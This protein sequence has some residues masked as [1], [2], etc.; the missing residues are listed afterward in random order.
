MT[1]SA[2]I[3]AA[4]QPIT[5]ATA[6]IARRKKTTAQGGKPIASAAFHT[7]QKA[8]AVCA[9]L[10]ALL[11]MS[12]GALKA[13]WQEVYGVPAPKNLSR[14]LMMYALSYEVQARAYGGLSHSIKQQLRNNAMA[15][16]VKA[17]TAVMPIKLS[18][19]MLLMRE[20][21]GVVHVVDQTEDGF[22]WNGKVHGSLSAIAR[23]ITG[24]RWNGLAFF[25]LR[26][27]K[28]SRQHILDK[29]ESSP[30]TKISTQAY[31]SDCD[32]NLN[33][34]TSGATQLTPTVSFTPSR[35]PLLTADPAP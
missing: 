16:S 30:S 23:A 11:D 4:L 32:A 14:R 1:T 10:A 33:D 19:G 22:M 15:S 20:W 31:D 18:P 5:C 9:D 35:A 26:K 7:S 3:S 21:R 25:G 29:C 17:Q 8:E 12:H 34:R 27:R 2:H 24:V 28:E 6:R 13:K